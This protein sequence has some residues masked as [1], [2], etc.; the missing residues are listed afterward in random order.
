MS[1]VIVIVV[2]FV[3]VVC[4]ALWY[5]LRPTRAERAARSHREH[6]ARERARFQRAPRVGDRAGY[7]VKP[8]P[9][10]EWAVGTIVKVTPDNVTVYVPD[11][12]SAGSLGEWLPGAR[13]T[14]P[15][16]MLTWFPPTTPLGRHDGHPDGVDSQH[17]DQ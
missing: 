16:S 3:F 8:A 13:W 11:E 1:D 10:S 15:A 14:C 2:G 17:V 9:I 5:W 6:V 7:E 4:C 12:R